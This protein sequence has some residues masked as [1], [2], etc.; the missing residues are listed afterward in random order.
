MNQ[1]VLRIVALPLAHIMGLFMACGLGHAIPDSLERDGYLLTPNVCRGWYCYEEPLVDDESLPVDPLIKTPVTGKAF[2]GE[3]DWE[4]AWTM[5]PDDLKQLI[6]D[7][8]AWAQQDP[9]D[10]KRMVDYMTLQG[11]AMRRAKAFQESWSE[12]LLK[13][14][15][16]DETTQRAP[17]TLGS[18]LEAVASRENE[19]HVLG[20]MRENMGILYFYSPSCAYCAKQTEILKMFV[21]KWNWANFQAINIDENPE[22]VG[23]YGVQSVPDLWVAGLVNGEVQQRRIKAGLADFGAIE[24]G[25]MNAWSQWFEGKRYE[26]P[27]LNRQL[28]NFDGF[29]QTIVRQ[30]G[31]RP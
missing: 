19:E 24:R 15:V 17:S 27:T 25:L 12:V 3:I 1:A 30:E 18:G 10:E 8:M 14:P 13:Y 22:V 9:R 7:S 26:R 21:E 5:H 2:R 29:L 31:G 16:L 4:A 23:K 6:D 11:V 20:Q 28:Q